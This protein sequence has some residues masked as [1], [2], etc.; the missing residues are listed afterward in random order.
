MPATDAL[1]EFALPCISP[2]LCDV[3][4]VM[5]TANKVPLEPPLT[6]TERAIIKSYG[7]WTNFMQSMGLKPWDEEDADE[8]KAIV[9]AFAADKEEE[10][11]EKAKK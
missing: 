9:A 2:R 10:D 3:P 4:A 7:G 5:T 11:K 6:P 1:R 8:G